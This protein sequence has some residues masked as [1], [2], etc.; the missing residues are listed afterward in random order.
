MILIYDDEKLA[1]TKHQRNVSNT[2]L[3]PAKETVVIPA[4]F[5]KKKRSPHNINR[6][7]SRKNAKSSRDYLEHFARVDS[8]VG[9]L[10]VINGKVAGMDCFGKPDVLGKIFMKMIEG[11]ARNA[12]DKYDPQMKLRSSKTEA[13]NFFQMARE[14]RFHTKQSDRLA[15]GWTLK[16]KC[17]AEHAFAHDDRVISLSMVAKN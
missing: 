12:A 13:M 2:I 4:S 14:S 7:R 15:A 9:A 16:S 10:F 6:T 17:C 11:Y 8:Q 1:K 5:I 3:I